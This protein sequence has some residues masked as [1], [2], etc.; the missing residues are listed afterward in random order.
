MLIENAPG[1]R[2]TPRGVLRAL[3][4]A[5]SL[6]GLISA[7]VLAGE[8]KLASDWASEHAARVRL[9]GGSVTSPEGA[10]RLFA[11]VE[12]QLDDGWKTYWRNPGTSGV[13]PRFEWTGS[14]NLAEASPRY[15]APQRFADKEGDTIGYK[16]AVLFPIEVT[17]KDPAK[18]V[19][20]KL[21]LEIGVCKDVCI[22]VQPVLELSLPPRSA[23]PSEPMLAEALER[24]PR[25]AG[26]RSSDPTLTS[27]KVDLRSDKPTIVI[28][29]RFPGQGET[30][31]V[32]LEAPDGL[33]I[34]LPKATGAKSGPDRTF[35]VDLTDGADIGDLKGRT[36]R[37]TL[38]GDGGASETSFKL[39]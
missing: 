33:W 39:E 8:P 4:A 10:S 38:V 22:P 18:P 23:A 21:S 24:V 29:A 9:I 25:P 13:P 14:E 11:A 32:F 3:A 19:T 2:P 27:L 5:A 31:D 28:A 35:L 17:P 7:G 20:L 1:A 30:A 16:K 12:I 37:A 15:P 6:I 26:A 36:I 34:P